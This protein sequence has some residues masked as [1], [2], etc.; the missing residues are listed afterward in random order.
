MGWIFGTVKYYDWRAWLKIRSQSITASRV[1]RRSLRICLACLRAP[2]KS[3]Q[4]F[5][6]NVHGQ[7]CHSRFLV[8]GKFMRTSA[9]KPDWYLLESSS[10]VAN[11]FISSQSKFK[12]VEVASSVCVRCGGMSQSRHKNVCCTRPFDFN[13]YIFSLK[14][15]THP[16]NFIHD[17]CRVCVCSHHVLRQN[18]KENTEKSE[19]SHS[20]RQRKNSCASSFAMFLQTIFSSKILV[21]LTSW[22]PYRESRVQKV[23]KRGLC[24]PRV[25]ARARTTINCLIFY[26]CTFCTG[27]SGI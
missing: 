21:Y 14:S 23:V 6:K 18:W 19:V 2:P 13:Y 8:V 9:K 10:F 24:V 12:W 16:C 1:T 5:N 17:V 20:D 26:L 3:T 27:W 4:P 11:W 7:F 22:R 25:C 15:H